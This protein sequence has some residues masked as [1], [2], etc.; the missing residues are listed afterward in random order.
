MKIIYSPITNSK[1]T[2]LIR[3][4]DKSKFINLY[5]KTNNIDVARFFE[6]TPEILYL[7][8]L[9]SGY[10]FFLPFSIAGDEIFYEDIQNIDWYYQ[11][12]KWEFSQAIKHIKKGDK[13]L[14]IG[15]G[16]G[17]F[18]DKIKNT[19]EV[20]AIEFNNAAI[21]K[22]ESKGYTVFK[23]SIQELSETKENFYDVI[24]IY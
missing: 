8:C 22:L 18:L 14:E 15:A 11:N 23:K 13:V 2:I 1:N 10:K 24:D 5:E 7:K 16:W 17:A 12:D 6:E 4:Y 3:K 9:D 21:R 19:N 20:E